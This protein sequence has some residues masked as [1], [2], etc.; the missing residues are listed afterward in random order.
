MILFETE[1]DIAAFVETNLKTQE[2][3][4]VSGYTWVGKNRQHKEEGGVGYFIKN[5]IKNSCTVES[6]NNTTTEILWIKLKLKGQENLFIGVLYGKQESKHCRKELEEGYEVIER[7]VY[8]YTKTNNKI[9][10]VGDFNGKIGNDENGITNGDT[11][12]TANGRRVRSMVRTLNMVILNKHAKCEGKWTKV[13][14]KN[15]NEKSIIDYAIR[16]KTIEKYYEGINR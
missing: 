2:K 8:S 6:D 4:A 16:S 10:L 7:S 1:P 15:C 9:I 11:Y 12:I 5:S 13:N 14:T 3:I